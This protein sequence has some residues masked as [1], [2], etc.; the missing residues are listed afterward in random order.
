MTNQLSETELQIVDHGLTAVIRLV[1]EGR[2]GAAHKN[3]DAFNLALAGD[4]AVLLRLMRSMKEEQDGR[5]ARTGGAVVLRK[6]DG[7]GHDRIGHTLG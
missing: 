1:Q 5:D 4:R 2:E 6:A 3:K 7:V